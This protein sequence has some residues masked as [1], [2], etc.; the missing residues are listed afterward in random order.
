MVDVAWAGGAIAVIAVVTVEGIYHIAAV[1]IIMSI[2]FTNE[3]KGG[4]KGSRNRKPLK[5]FKLGQY[6][7]CMDF[8]PLIF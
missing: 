7:K 5:S 6:F 3:S 1:L 2:R 4:S 8:F